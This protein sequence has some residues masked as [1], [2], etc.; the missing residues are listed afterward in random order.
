M[1]RKA[2]QALQAHDRQVGELHLRSLFA[3]DPSR[4]ERMTAEAVGLVLD[5]SKNRIS[6]ETVKLLAQLAVESDLRGRIDSMFRG[7]KINITE[8]SM[9]PAMTV[10]WTT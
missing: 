10:Q 8:P 3:D 1:K 6:D 9:R 4:G 2:W 5:Y 7:A